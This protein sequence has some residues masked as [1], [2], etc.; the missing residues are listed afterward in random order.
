MKKILFAFIGVATLFT[1]SCKKDGFHESKELVSGGASG[2]DTLVG[3]I[4]HDTTVVR[5]TYLKG[6]VYVAPG[7]TLRINAGVTIKGSSGCSKRRQ[8]HC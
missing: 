8:A 3:T 5:T 6:I 1:V 7:A 4:S 2:V